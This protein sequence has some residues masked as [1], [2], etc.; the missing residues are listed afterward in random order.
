MH[1]IWHKIGTVPISLINSAHQT[2]K[3]W[4]KWSQEIFKIL[5]LNF[6]L[7]KKNITDLQQ[8]KP[9]SQTPRTKDPHSENA[10]I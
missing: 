7:M 8:K 10:P 4:K 3:L 2:E 9:P 5:K 6:N 1:N